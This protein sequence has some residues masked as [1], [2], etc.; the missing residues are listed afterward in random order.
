MTQETV[1][2]VDFQE[3]MPDYRQAVSELDDVELDLPSTLSTLANYLLNDDNADEALEYCCERLFQE[4]MKYGVK[5]EESVAVAVGA[6][7]LGQHLVNVLR[8]CELYDQTGWL[9]DLEFL[10]FRNNTT[11]LFK[12]IYPGATDDAPRYL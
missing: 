3:V 9:G 10:K 11:A 5:T 4:H 1:L 2:I 12:V 6:Q 7:I 8:N